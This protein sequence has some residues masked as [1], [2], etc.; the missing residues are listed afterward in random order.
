MSGLPFKRRWA[1]GL[2]KRA[3][4]RGPTARWSVPCSCKRTRCR[5][6]GSANASSSWRPC[7]FSEARY[8]SS[9]AGEPWGEFC[10]TSMTTPTTSSMSNASLSLRLAASGPQPFVRGLSRCVCGASE[11]A[12]SW[13]G[14]TMA[15]EA[16]CQ[17]K[18]DFGGK[19]RGLQPRP[20]GRGARRKIYSAELRFVAVWRLLHH[21]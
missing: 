4:A 9:V 19:G 1:D 2:K 7:S 20:K 21:P 5:V 14:G 15:R 12:P 17:K 16:R 3:R 11:E 10:V 6:C 8:P 13:G 18:R